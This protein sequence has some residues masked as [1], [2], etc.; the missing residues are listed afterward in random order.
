MGTSALAPEAKPGSPA[1]AAAAATAPP[2]L[3]PGHG[4]TATF[5]DPLS[6]HMAA[7]G[8]AKKSQGLAESSRL[9]GD[10]I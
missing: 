10:G 3:L 2:H 4:P 5:R 1:A 8:M 7:H 6:C 9:H